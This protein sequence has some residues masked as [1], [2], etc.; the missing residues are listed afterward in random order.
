MGLDPKLV[1]AIEEFTAKKRAREKKMAKLEKRAEKG[2][3]LGKAARNEIEQMMSQ[4]LTAMNR[5]ELT[6]N[7]AKKK[8]KKRKWSSCP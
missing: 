7:A 1:A 5:I 4:D 8:G 2:G 3:V 6:L